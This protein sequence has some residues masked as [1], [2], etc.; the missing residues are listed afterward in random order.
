M[1]TGIDKQEMGT[2]QYISS[3][4]GNLP[5]DSRKKRLRED[6][7]TSGS[8]RRRLSTDGKSSEHMNAD[9]K[10]SIR[11]KLLCLPMGGTSKP[12]T[13]S[14]ASGAN[15]RDY[16][17]DSRLVGAQDTDDVVPVNPTM[18]ESVTINREL[19]GSEPGVCLDASLV[20]FGLRVQLQDSALVDQIHM[21]SASFFKRMDAGKKACD[22]RRVKKW[23][24]KSD[25][26]SKKF[27]IVPV[28]D[29]YYLLSWAYV[30]RHISSTTGT[31][32][33]LLF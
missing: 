14:T 33:V 27:I 11:L 7:S 5:H 19:A 17:Q 29:L 30:K 32:G 9:P 25:I 12:K 13:R 15:H 10:P 26:F 23:S 1:N 3:N 8:F 4:Q 24:W 22:Y 20:E 21:F 28:N 2:P 16:K 6:D 31:I 18:T